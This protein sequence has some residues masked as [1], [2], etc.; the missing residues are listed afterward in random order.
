MKNN[1]IFTILLSLLSLNF[2]NVNEF[3]RDPWEKKWPAG[4][5]W[6]CERASSQPP[7][8]LPAGRRYCHG[9]SVQS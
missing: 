2:R 8:A 6:A 1:K 5:A 9:Q 7:A 3:S 4:R